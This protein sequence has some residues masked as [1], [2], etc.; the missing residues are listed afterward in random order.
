MIE[1]DFIEKYRHVPTNAR[2]CDQH[3]TTTIMVVFAQ[4]SPDGKG[5]HE[6]EASIFMPPEK[7][8][9]VDFHHHAL[10]LMLEC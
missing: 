4:H 10:Q 3:A 1:T 6:T 8:H 9:D 5:L 7:Q 2:T